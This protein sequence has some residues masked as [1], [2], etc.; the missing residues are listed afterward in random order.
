MFHLRFAVV[1]DAV[2]CQIEVVNCLGQ[3]MHS[4]NY[5]ELTGGPLFLDLSGCEKGLY[6]FKIMIN[7]G[8]VTKKIVI[9]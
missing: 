8:V 1:V 6:F 3:S 9:N 5:V 2:E 7:N 4:S